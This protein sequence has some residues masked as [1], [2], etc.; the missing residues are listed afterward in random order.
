[1]YV[2][3]GL[4]NPGQEYAH[5]RHSV[6]FLTVDELAR[7]AGVRYWKT[8]HGCLT[9]KVRIGGEEAV[10]AKPQSFM[11]VSGGPVKQVAKAYK[12]DGKHLIVVHD[13]VDLA[14]G[15]VRVK[16]GGGLNAHNGLRSIAAKTGTHDWLRVRCGIGRPP[17]R[18][19]V[20][21]YV[22]QDVRKQQLDELLATADRAADAVEALVTQG[23]AKAER[24]FNR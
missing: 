1:M 20:A 6:G 16:F 14:P 8:E 18:M 15:E 4:G 9:A 12:A 22:L 17:G 2:V 19:K 5:T 7:R 11:N 3:A 24:R 23:F 10:L 13:E 21:D